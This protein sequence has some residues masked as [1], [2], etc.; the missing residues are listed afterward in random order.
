MNIKLQ[1]TVQ[2]HP[3]D[4]DY[5]QI[6]FEPESFYLDLQVYDVIMSTE[7]DYQAFHYLEKENNLNFKYPKLAKKGFLAFKVCSNYAFAAIDPKYYDEAIA[8]QKPIRKLSIG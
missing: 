6:V 1:F 7:S 2:T 8:T 5:F 3:I 4:S